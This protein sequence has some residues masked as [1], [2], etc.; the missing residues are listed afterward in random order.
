MIRRPPRSTRTDT[1]V[2]YTTLFRSLADEADGAVADLHLD[3]VVGHL[4][5]RAG[6]HVA[7]LQLLGAAGEGILAELLDAEA[8]A[9]LVA[10]D[11]EHLDLDDSSEA[12]RVGQES[13][14]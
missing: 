6:H 2:P 10:V 5:H 1:L 3:A 11:V 7:L 13:V 4:M 8:D 14:R 9:L 12:R